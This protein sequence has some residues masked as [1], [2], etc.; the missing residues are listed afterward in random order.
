M[1]GEGGPGDNSVDGRGVGKGRKQGWSGL[2]QEVE[3][4]IQG[5][6]SCVPALETPSNREDL[7]TQKGLRPADDG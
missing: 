7:A 4:G 6:D 2:N 5:V 3:R 1:G